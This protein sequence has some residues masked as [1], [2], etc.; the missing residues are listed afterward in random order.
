MRKSSSASWASI[1]QPHP[2]CDSEGVGVRA[3]ACV[4]GG[5]AGACHG[6][7][8]T[9][10]STGDAHAAQAHPSAADSPRGTSQAPSVRLCVHREPAPAQGSLGWAFLR[11]L[12]AGLV[13]RHA[14]SPACRWGLWA[15]GPRPPPASPP[16]ISAA[17]SSWHWAWTWGR[18]VH[19][20]ASSL[21]CVQQQ[22][23][24]RA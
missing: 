16:R 10:H 7:P 21:P 23:Q 18:G 20:E 11:P 1:S 3:C 8:W 6:R 17:P 12:S 19:K 13:Q 9:L 24:G 2:S 4:L 14:R 22:P 5:C 15:S